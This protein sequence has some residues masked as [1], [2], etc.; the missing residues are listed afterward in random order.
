LTQKIKKNLVIVDG[1]VICIYP[2]AGKTLDNLCYEFEYK[3]KLYVGQTGASQE[4][5][6]A[7]PGQS[8]SVFIDSLDPRNQVFGGLGAEFAE[9]NVP[10]NYEGEVVW[11]KGGC[12]CEF[13]HR[14]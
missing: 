9:I 1:T 5:L 2:L 4:L 3:G 11:I 8:C 6:S 7:R 12:N 13:G 10:A 14:L